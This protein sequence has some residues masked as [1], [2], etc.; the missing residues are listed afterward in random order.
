M[1]TKAILLAFCIVMNGKIESLN[2]DRNS[3]FLEW[4]QE[5]FGIK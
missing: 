4:A 2:S 1:I 5:N 3:Y